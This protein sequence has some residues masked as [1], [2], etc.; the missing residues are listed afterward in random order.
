VRAVN[1]YTELVSGPAA[2]G[3]AGVA[4]LRAL[5]RLRLAT[6][7]DFDPVVVEALATVLSRGVYGRPR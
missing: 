5:E 1:A 3:A 6:A 7:R 4:A 2:E